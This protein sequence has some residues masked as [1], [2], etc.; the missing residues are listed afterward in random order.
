MPRRTMPHPNRLN[1]AIE[2][3]T[4]LTHSIGESLGK[5]LRVSDG[6]RAAGPVTFKTEE[7]PPLTALAKI[8]AGSFASRIGR[9]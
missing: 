1:F 4:W 2:R 9:R 8:R 6:S 3:K 7:H 5:S